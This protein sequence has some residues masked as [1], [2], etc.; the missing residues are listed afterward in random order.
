MDAEAMQSSLGVVGPQT[1]NTGIEA[2]TAS[3]P[4]NSPP[5]PPPLS[6]DTRPLLFGSLGSSNLVLTTY[7]LRDLDSITAWLVANGF[8]NYVGPIKELQ[9]DPA[10]FFSLN[11]R[12]LEK[13]N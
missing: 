9:L 1:S 5:L 13:M 12:D 6:I 3:L 8:E 7:P 11:V 4:P 2:T 10:A